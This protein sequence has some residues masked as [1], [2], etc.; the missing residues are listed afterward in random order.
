MLQ[1]NLDFRSY[2][3]TSRPNF[4]RVGILLPSKSHMMFE[5][6]ISLFLYLETISLKFIL[7]KKCKIHKMSI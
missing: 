2:T 3:P 7:Y 4:I 1:G 5:Q 6:E